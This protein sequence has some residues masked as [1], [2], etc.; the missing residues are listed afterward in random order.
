M[1]A[2]RP[3]FTAA[4][5][6]TCR[7][8]APML[9]SS[10]RLVTDPF[11]MRVLGPAAEATV[12]AVSRSPAPV[13]AL[14]WAPMLPMLPWA[15]YMQ[16]RTKVLD[17]VVRSFVAAGGQQVVI[18]GAGFDARAWRLGE[19]LGDAIVYE[20]D[21][22]ATARAKRDRFG[23]TSRVRAL[24][25]DFEADELS[26]LPA[27]LEALGHRADQPTLTLWEGVTMYLTQRAFEATL[28]AVRA[29]SGRGSKLAFNYVDRGI[30]ERP[31]PAARAVSAIVRAVGEPFKLGFSPRALASLL[32]QHGFIVDEDRGFDEHASRL[33]PS[34]WSRVVRRGRRIAVVERSA[35]AVR[36]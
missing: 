3:S 10:A 22:P 30:V 34:P 4:F 8:L 31:S 23:E 15:L 17:D 21:H 13:R 9:P 35:T 26:S 24:D 36:R 6:A 25:F 28:D 14:A 20:V 5:V 12:A 19:E 11:G 18:L 7:G 1:K 33:L 27:R 2:G 29:Y 32:E 16:V